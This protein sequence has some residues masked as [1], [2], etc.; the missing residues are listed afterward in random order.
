MKNYFLF[1]LLIQLGNGICHSSARL[2]FSPQPLDT[3]KIYNVYCSFTE[4]NAVTAWGGNYSSF[5]PAEECPQKSKDKYVEN[6]KSI[7]HHFSSQKFFWMKLYNT[8]DQLIYESLKYGDCRVGKFICYW[9]N[10]KRKM[11][12]EYDG[13]Y[14]KKK[15]GEYIFKKCA[16]EQSGTW[17][18]YD[19]DGKFLRYEE[20]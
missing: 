8:K 9:P 10:G 18:Y 12:G 2:P 7:T 14:V 16:G 5:Y 11:T 19:E 20:Y 13:A 15:T 1:I 6:F 3:V 17:C 4:G